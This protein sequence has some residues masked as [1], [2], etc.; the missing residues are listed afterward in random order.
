MWNPDVFLEKFVSVCE[1]NSVPVMLVFGTCLGPIRDQQLISYDSD[2]DVG[3]Y[4]TDRS[5][6]VSL[7]SELESLE[8]Y[9]D[10]I[11]SHKMVFKSPHSLIVI[12]VWLIDRAYHPLMVLTGHRWFFE[13]GY[14]KK[15]F[16]N[17]NALGTALC[18]GRTYQVPN[19]VEEFLEDLYGHDWRIPIK[20]RHAVYRAFLSRLLHVIFLESDMPIRYSSQDDTVRFK[21]WIRGFM[22]RCFPTSRLT[23]KYGK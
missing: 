8:I 21:P 14:Y 1:K 16:F 13:S 17:P 2:L 22:T 3:C 11:D 7:F 6:L 5:K 10:K 23:K 9:P 19:L 18:N 12:D 4:F 20:G 15:D